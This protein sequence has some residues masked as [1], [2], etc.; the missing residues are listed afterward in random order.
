MPDE[1]VSFRHQCILISAFAADGPRGAQAE[2]LMAGV[3]PSVA[4]FSTDSPTCVA[5]AAL[6]VSADRC[7][8]RDDRRSARPCPAPLDRDPPRRSRAG[9]R[10]WVVLLRRPD[11]RCSGRCGLFCAV[12][13]GSAARPTIRRPPHREPVSSTGTV[14]PDWIA[15]DDLSQFTAH[16]L[17]VPIAPKALRSFQ[18]LPGRNKPAP[19]R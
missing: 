11:R 4:R 14:T 18:A 10:P 16:T 12:Q 2:A 19:H 5:Q 8:L 13:R 7:R 3:E 6:A 9:A 15:A 1:R 17:N